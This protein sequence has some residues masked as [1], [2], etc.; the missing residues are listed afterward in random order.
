MLEVIRV[1]PEKRCN[2]TRG[3]VASVTF[4]LPVVEQKEE[5]LHFGSEKK[6]YKSV[7]APSFKFKR[8]CLP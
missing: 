1:F 4:D 3:A 8:L 2:L 7:C 6:I 5:L